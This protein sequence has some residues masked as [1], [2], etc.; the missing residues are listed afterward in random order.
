MT[1]PNH[2]TPQSRPIMPSHF[3]SYGWGS[4]PF[5]LCSFSLGRGDP[6]LTSVELLHTNEKLGSQQSPAVP[7][8]RR[9]TSQHVSNNWHV[10]DT[11]SS[12]GLMPAGIPY[13]ARYSANLSQIRRLLG[14]RKKNLLRFPNHK[15]RTSVEAA[16]KQ[17]GARFA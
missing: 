17:K 2:G 14:T 11:M 9:I 16:R 3:Q 13:S 1:I 6:S 7:W 12:T 8:E 5:K 4:T 10:T 15:G